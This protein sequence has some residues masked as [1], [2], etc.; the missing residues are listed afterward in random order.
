GGRV[1]A[2]PQVRRRGIPR[3]I[4]S[5][6]FLLILAL[7][8]RGLRETVVARQHLEFLA[9]AKSVIRR[10]TDWRLT[11]LNAYRSVVRKLGVHAALSR[12][13]RGQPVLVDEGTI[14][15]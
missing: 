5:R 10:D 9:F 2:A 1:P 6:R 11:G 13:P 12:R 15:S 14:H 4:V 3:P 8:L 7:D